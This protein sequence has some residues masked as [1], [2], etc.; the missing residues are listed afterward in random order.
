MQIEERDELIRRFGQYERLHLSLSFLAL[1]I[2]QLFSLEP[3]RLKEM[4]KIEFFQALRNS[5]R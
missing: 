3:I 1:S 2:S 4:G 5:M